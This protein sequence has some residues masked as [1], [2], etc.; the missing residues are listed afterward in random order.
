MPLLILSLIVQV[1]LVVHILKTGRNTYWV[2]IVMFFPLVGSLA[3]LIVELLPEFGNGRT[4]QRMRRNIVKT[5]NP[6]GEF[7]AAAEKLE[8][9]DTVRNSIALAEQCL[10]RSR[11][12]EARGLYERALKG[13]HVHDPLLL[14]GLAKAQFGLAQFDQTLQTLDLLKQNNPDA[15][16]ADAHLLY[17]RAQEGLGNADAAIHEYEALS[18]YYG[19]LE[20]LCRLALLH[21]SLGKDALALDL[22]ARALKESR[23]AGK[24]Y[25]SVNEEWIALAERE[26]DRA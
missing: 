9:A 25:R 20:P 6:D 1:G 17:A 19:G 12:D 7:R 16:S 2:F 14:L 11:F 4:A 8:V 24:H 18:G 5:V 26:S 15:K 13:I 23:L 10:E 22:F 21:R 3:Y